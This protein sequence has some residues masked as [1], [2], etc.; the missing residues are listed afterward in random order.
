MNKASSAINIELAIVVAGSI[1]VGVAIGLLITEAN[2][3]I[4]LTLLAI[5]IPVILIGMRA[6]QH[7]GV[8][9]DTLSNALNSAA[10]ATMLPTANPLPLSTPLTPLG[11]SLT[12]IGQQM[13]HL[14]MQLQMQAD[15]V[16]EVAVRIGEAA[17]QHNQSA[18]EQATAVT[19]VATAMTELDRIIASVTDLAHQVTA[20]ASEALQETRSSERAVDAVVNSLNTTSERVGETV[21]AMARLRDRISQIGLIS[22][23][24]ADVA[25][26]THLLS[27]NA[28]IESASAGEYG[29]RFSI[30]AEEVYTLAA[31]TREG[32]AQV[33]QLVQ[34]LDRALLTTEAAASAGLAQTSITAAMTNVL[35]TATNVLTTSAQRTQQL[36]TA[37]DQAMTQ[38]RIGASQVSTA[39]NS[40]A[41]SA[42]NMSSQSNA[43]A[44]RASDLTT[45]A[46]QLRQSALLFGRSASSDR[47]MR[48]LIAG[49]ETVSQ[50]GLAWSALVDGWNQQHTS[51]RIAI[52]FI[53]PGADYIPNLRLALAE[54]RAPDIIQIPSNA[55]FGILAVGDY[56]APLDGLLK[57]AVRSDFYSQ[58]L[59]PSLSDGHLYTLPTEAQPLVL[60]YSKNLLAQLGLDVPHSWDELIALGRRCRQVGRWGIVMDTA[61]GD[62]R[63]HEWMPFVWQ[64][65]TEINNNQGRLRMT[66]PAAQAALQ[67]WHELFVGQQV[68][69]LKLP[70]PSY[71]IAN[72]AEGHCAIQYIGTWGMNMLRE[73]YPN[74]E[75]GIADLPLPANGQPATMLLTWGLAVNASSL[76]RE[77]AAEFVRWALASEGEDGIARVHSL[78]VEGLPVRRSEVALVNR[79]GA[80]DPNWQYLLEQ[81]YPHAHITPPLSDAEVATADKMIDTAI[82]LS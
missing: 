38:Q 81:V 27:L 46:D 60:F 43:V 45:V 6:L 44:T 66:H 53:P 21:G 48:L 17:A 28:A 54:H 2:W 33:S 32:S 62:F 68:A 57:S 73:S 20:A 31:R 39:L 71:D 8:A 76:M 82:S 67:L 55:E 10:D 64:G 5:G 4:G 77:A 16:R 13:R 14:I 15:Q 63:L 11:D 19:E 72:L 18:A 36:A 25:H 65:E 29:M 41:D 74:F 26:D 70:Y 34:E 30:I 69:P 42:R 9:L 52:E 7:T 75:Y 50:R 35:T 24:L 1:M 23:L 80:P 22:R 56:L 47:A 78:M 51:A 49:R 79:A 61:P 58:L 59:T 37:I 40:I 3:I 12:R